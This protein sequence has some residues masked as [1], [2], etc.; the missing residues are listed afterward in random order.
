MYRRAED[1]SNAASADIRKVR[2][3]GRTPRSECDFGPS[4]RRH[5]FLHSAG[6]RARL[7]RATLATMVESSG[8]SGDSSRSPLAESPSP[9]QQHRSPTSLSLCGHRQQHL[10]CG[11]PEALGRRTT[12][13]PSAPATS[14]F[15][16]DSILAPKPMGNLAA[17]AVAAAANLAS[18]ERS[19]EAGANLGSASAGSAHPFQQQ[20]HQLAFSS[21]DFLGESLHLY[22]SYQVSV[23]TPSNGWVP[24]TRN[25]RKNAR[26][27][28][29]TRCSD[30]GA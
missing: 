20:L 2:V 6:Q 10:Y 15:T 19:V 7:P 21:A 17:A 23:G 8:Y 27:G 11:S 22:H 18:I 30:L 29:R 1:C 28:G 4:V 13:G 3:A 9:I 12:S 14:L 25:T 24:S 16:I 5:L 26:S